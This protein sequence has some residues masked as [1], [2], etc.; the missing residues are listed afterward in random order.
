MDKGIYCLIFHNPACTAGIG[1]LGEIAFRK[2]WHVYIGSAL[3]A[4]G[5]KRLERHITLAEKKDKRPKWHVDWLL[6]NAN[7]PLRYAVYAP[8]TLRLE[9]ILA[10]A[11]G[12][13]HVPL[14]GCS[15]CACPSHL[16]FR[17]TDPVQEVREVFRCLKLVPATKTIK[18]P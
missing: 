2:G 9:C 14:F 6:T 18:S 3:G 15:D 10:S 17:E 8:T 5:L 13:E 4:G 1:A 7:F 16:L 12:G 11:L